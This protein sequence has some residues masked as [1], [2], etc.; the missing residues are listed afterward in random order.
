MSSW[1][2]KDGDSPTSLDHLLLRSVILTVEY[3]SLLLSRI[4]CI[5]VFC[6]LPL[7]LS[8]GTTKINLTLS[9]LLP[10]QV[11]GQDF[12]HEHS[13]LQADQFCLPVSQHRADAPFSLNEHHG[14]VWHSLQFVMSLLYWGVRWETEHTDV[15][16]HGWERD[17]LPWVA[18]NALTAHF[19]SLF[20]SQIMGLKAEASSI[21]H[22]ESL[23]FPTRQPCVCL[24]FPTQTVPVLPPVQLNVQALVTAKFWGRSEQLLSI[25]SATPQSTDL[26]PQL[27]SWWEER[28]STSPQLLQAMS[29]PSIQP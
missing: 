27:F 19:F 13:L 4:F 18:A 5:S 12:S 26:F 28:P 17:Y 9:P 8:R 20:E 6:P 22:C 2:S 14:P 15:S 21:G 7:F 16:H 3:F 25:I 24:H 11:F 29:P 1:V 10:H 23:C